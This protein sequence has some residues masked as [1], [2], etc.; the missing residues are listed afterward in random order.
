MPYS[1]LAVEDQI[2]LA[3]EFVGRGVPV[4]SEIRENLGSNLM[5][6]I[7]NPETLHDRD[8]ER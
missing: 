8:Q 1:D 7:E 3:A 6:D 5:R 2:L 4:P